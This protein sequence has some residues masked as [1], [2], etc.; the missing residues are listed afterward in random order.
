MHAIEHQPVAQ[1]GPPPAMGF[2]EEI[3]IHSPG[4][5]REFVTL[6]ITEFLSVDSWKLYKISAP[7]GRKLVSRD[8]VQNLIR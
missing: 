2:G 6:A 4:L 3:S 1:A 7:E 5:I 8:F